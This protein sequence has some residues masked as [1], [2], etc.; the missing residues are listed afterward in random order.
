VIAF[1]EDAVT[2]LVCLACVALVVM[3]ACRGT[4]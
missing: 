3:Y 4:E 1:L 2:I